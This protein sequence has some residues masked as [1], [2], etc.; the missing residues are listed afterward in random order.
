MRLWRVIILLNLALA[1]GLLLGYLAW[2][3]QVGALEQELA[4][5]RQSGTA[6]GIEQVFTTQ[7]VVRALIPEINVV[8][9]THDEI[10]GFMPAMTM[11][12]RTAEPQ[13]FR[14]VAV[15][16]VVRFT[17]KGVPPNVLITE[18]VKEGRS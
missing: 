2:G 4:L 9:L 3:R 1:I 18:M 5:T 12:F 13:L 17:L 10:K 8:V 15:G 6:P 16:D 11:G 14:G 7:G